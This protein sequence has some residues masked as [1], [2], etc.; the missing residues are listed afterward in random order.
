[1]ARVVYA[2]EDPSPFASGQGSERLRNA[3]IMVEGGLLADQATF[4]YAAWLKDLRNQ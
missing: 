2:C 4:L 1:V 3:G